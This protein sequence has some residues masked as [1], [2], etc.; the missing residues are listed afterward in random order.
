MSCVQNLN[1]FPL[2]SGIWRTAALQVSVEAETEQLI[3]QQH[4]LNVL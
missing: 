1:I 3:E 4:N 2:Q